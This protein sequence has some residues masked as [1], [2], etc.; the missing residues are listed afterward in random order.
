MYRVRNLIW[1]RRA[2]QAPYAKPRGQRG[3]KALG[4]RFERLVARAATL[5]CP[6][7]EHGAWF[8]F[9]DATL[10]AGQLGAGH[11]GYCSPDLLLVQGPSAL[12]VE[13]KL[14]DWQGAWE[15]L[16]WLYTPVV[17]M[18]LQTRVLPVVVVKHVSPGVTI[19]TTLREAIIRRAERPVLH[20]LGEGTF[21][22]G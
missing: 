7:L 18:A 19:V 5:Q 6:G 9:Q 3:T 13:V 15:Q 22:L 10:G 1:A 16:Q 12:V 8:Q 11:R 14:T 2:F 4:L 17:E 21:P 20:W